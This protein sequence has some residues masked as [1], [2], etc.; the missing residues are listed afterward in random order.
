MTQPHQHKFSDLAPEK[1]NLELH[2]SDCARPPQ[3]INIYDASRADFFAMMIL[4]EGR[5]NMKINLKE[6]VITKNSMLFLAPNMLKQLVNATE[7]TRLYK[8]IFTSGFLLQI[9]IQKHEIEMIDF[10]SR[11]RESIIQLSDQ[12]M[13]KILKLMEDLK[14]KNEHA[15]EHP[16]GED[17]VQYTFRIFLSEMAAIGIN[18]NVGAR[19]SKVSRKEDLTMRF[20]NLINLHFKEHRAVKYYAERLAITPNYLN[21]IIHEVTGKSAGELIDEKVMH[22]AKVLLNNPRLTIAQIAE[23]LHFSDQSFLG[24]FFKRHLGISP[25]EYRGHHLTP[26]I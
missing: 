23:L 12:E 1:R 11:S 14:E 6:H 22:E 9:G 4:I 2:V 8:V 7:D 5:I 3:N 21:E 26:S 24:K 19:K 16:F 10:I 20:G 15:A 13:S 17:I 18:H 25:S